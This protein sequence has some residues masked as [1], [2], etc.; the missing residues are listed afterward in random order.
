M[1]DSAPYILIVLLVAGL[2]I[3][4]T[5]ICFIIYFLMKKKANARHVEGDDVTEEEIISMV[6][7]GHEQGTILQSEAEMI[8]NIFEFSDTQADDIMTVRKNVAGINEETSFDEAI[9]YLLG[10]NYSRFP[11][12]KDDIDHIIGILHI[13][14]AFVYYRKNKDTKLKISEIPGLV[15]DPLFIP[16]TQNIDI[17]F[18]TMQKTKKHMVIVVDEYG[19]TSGI[20]TMEDI[21]EEIFGNIE[22]EHD[23]AENMII[24]RGVGSFIID[25]RAELDDVEEALGIETDIDDI[26]TLN[27]LIVALIDKIPEDNERFE[28]SYKGYLFKA[29]SVKN[30]TVKSVLAVKLDEEKEEKEG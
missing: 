29:L 26:D 6:N 25:G 19:Q 8:N 10:E 3:L 30:K 13:K 18:K 17:L 14:D 20:V 15:S 21:L 7:E 16:E 11:V 27:G 22:D 28:V 24:K 2:L 5:L 4:S 12:Y 23:K 1:D 9:D